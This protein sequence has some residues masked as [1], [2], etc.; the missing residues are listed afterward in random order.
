MLDALIR[1]LR[2]AIRGMIRRPG[3]ALSTVG[4]LGLGI[5]AA[6]A[7]FT[8]VDG[9]LLRPLPYPRPDRI[10]WVREVAPDGH[11]M[12]LADP[13]F[14]DIHSQS[15]S[16]AA[17]AEMSGTVPV[18]VTG[19]PEPVRG[20]A[21]AVS[22][23]FFRVMGVEASRG[24]TFLPEES[25]QGAAPAV[26]VS[27]DFW[28]RSLGG[29]SLTGKSL[30]F[31]NRL[32]SVVGVMP[33]GFDYPPGTELWT[34]A[35]LSPHGTSRTAHNW[36]VVGRLAEGVSLSGARA[37][38]T[39]IAHR[40]T[41]RHGDDIDLVDVSA[42][43]LRDA[44]V[45]P[46]RTPLLVL[47]GAAA[48]LL[49][50]AVSNVGNL[51]LARMTARRR[52]LAVR[53]ALGAGRG[54]LVRQLA[55]ESLVLGLV[56]GALGV[57][58]ALAGTRFLLTLG[59]GYLPRM[60]EIGVDGG[61]LAFALAVSVVAAVGLG[62]MEALAGRAD[63]R[64]A[65]AAGRRTVAGGGGG[66][67]VRDGLV[68][69]QMALTLVLLAGAALMGRS[70][71]HLLS[72]PTGFRTSDVLV[73]NVAAAHP[74]DEALVRSFEDRLLE[75]L[76][77]L[78]GVESVGGIS[79]FPLQDG[80]PDGTYLAMDRP[81]EARSIEDFERLRRIPGRSGSALWCVASEGYFRALGIPLL[82]GRWFSDQDAPA[83][84]L[85]AALVSESFASRQWHGQNPIG[86]IIQFGN[87][88]G[89]LRPLRVVGVVGDVRSRS[90][91]KEPYPTL[92]A[93]YRQRPRTAARFHVA[94]HTRGDPAALIPAA[95]QA[96]RDADPQ[97]PPSFR[98]MAQVLGSVTADRRFALL[99]LGV[100]GLTALLLAVTGIYGVVAYLVAQRSRELGVRIAFGARPGDLVRLLVGRSAILTGAGIGL[101]I[102]AALALT[103]LLSGLLYGIT[104][105]DPLA[106]LVGALVLAAAA[107]AA[108]WLPARR[109]GRLD[110]ASSLN[111]D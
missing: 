55:A 78:P 59:P 77:A 17:L 93:Y 102:L 99:L 101:G 13:N 75:R 74:G 39:A 94:I 111:A 83:A 6:S 106:Y 34:P 90:V 31:Q 27:W 18:S 53:R 87:M 7:I 1:D 10:A 32:F 20:V 86:K 64:G 73:M 54:R 85:N 3:F 63:L 9:V 52:E 61:V 28:Q 79:G 49:L 96:L 24:R 33:R 104:A 71:L 12:A 98:T 41:A 38:L 11:G 15:R 42:I 48:F 47:L 16:F 84:A 26:V 100:F 19:G 14:Q 51:L 107:L 105:T 76:R 5:G 45:G 58:L 30:N 56:A 72:V 109:A 88:D 67:L 91:A 43:P 66:R 103:R 95:R 25:R 60:G 23:G 108:S 50:I 65:L 82:R 89:D 110:P 81:D 62:I 4:I 8:V 92:Y 80:C 2:Y 70:L 40:L 36:R 37:E 44:L 29:G 22:A 97:V 35:E 68:V 21:A 46:V 57:L 69:A